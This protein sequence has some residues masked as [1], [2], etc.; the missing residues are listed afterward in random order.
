MI[1]YDVLHKTFGSNKNIKKN[2]HSGY[3]K[4]YGKNAF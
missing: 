2:I 3:L 1:V 4:F